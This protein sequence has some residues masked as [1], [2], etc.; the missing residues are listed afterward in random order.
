MEPAQRRT[1][2]RMIRVRLD[3]GEHSVSLALSGGGRAAGNVF[4]VHGDEVV[5][6]DGAHG[7]C[8]ESVGE[9]VEGVVGDHG[10]RQKTV[11]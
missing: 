3:F 2:C 4:G 5:Y 11:R 6:D 10:G 9:G 1:Y 7:E 8:A